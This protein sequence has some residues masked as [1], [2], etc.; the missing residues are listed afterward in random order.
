MNYLFSESLDSSSLSI[1]MLRFLD[2]LLI[3]ESSVGGGTLAALFLLLQNGKNN[4]R[5]WWITIDRLGRQAGLM[6]IRNHFLVSCQLTSLKNIAQA[7]K[8]H[9]NKACFFSALF[10]GLLS[11]SSAATTLTLE[12]S[13]DF[14]TFGLEKNALEIKEKIIK[15]HSQSQLTF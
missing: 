7:G 1:L 14:A 2:A 15:T 11:L 5:G 12:V 8:T 9:G 13:S 3:G 4:G 10:K 6:F